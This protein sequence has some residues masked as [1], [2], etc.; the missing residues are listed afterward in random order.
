MYISACVYISRSGRAPCGKSALLWGHRRQTQRSLGPTRHATPHDCARHD[1]AHRMV[2]Y[3]MVVHRMS[4]Y[5]MSVYCPAPWH[6]SPVCSLLLR[7]AGLPACIS[8][9]SRPAIM[10]GWR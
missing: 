1:C 7:E 5:R 2:V 4:V 8:D 6:D 10:R 9:Q 3:R